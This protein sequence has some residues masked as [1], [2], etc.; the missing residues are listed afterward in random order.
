MIWKALQAFVKYLVLR[1]DGQLA[2]KCTGKV[3][4][5][6][7]QSN[8]IQQSEHSASAFYIRAV[9]PGARKRAQAHA[10]KGVERCVALPSGSTTTR[11]LIRT[12]G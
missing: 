11:L 2:T 12:Q 6:G 4:A 7:E 5:L 9:K 10:Y 3:S 1:I 8:G